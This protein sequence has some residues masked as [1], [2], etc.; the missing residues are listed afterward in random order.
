MEYRETALQQGQKHLRQQPDGFRKP[1]GGKPCVV[2]HQRMGKGRVRTGGVFRQKTQPDTGL[3][4]QTAQFLIRAAGVQPQQ[5]VQPGALLGKV[6]R[7]AS[8]LERK[9]STT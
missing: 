1:L 4:G 2:D 6:T 9:A 5:E 7:G 8:A 3:S